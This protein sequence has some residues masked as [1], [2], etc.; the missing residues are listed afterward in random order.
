MVPP[1]REGGAGRSGSADRGG[2]VQNFL[3][4][5]GLSRFGLSAAGASESFFF[6]FL[7]FLVLA[8]FWLPAPSP[9]SGDP[10]TLGI[11]P[12]VS[13]GPPSLP[14]PPAS[15]SNRILPDSSRSISRH[16]STS[17]LRLRRGVG[18][19][20]GGMAVA[21]PPP[22]DRPSPRAAWSLRYDPRRPFPT[23]GKEGKGV[24]GG[25]S[26]RTTLPRCRERGKATSVSPEPGSPGQA[27]VRT[28]APA[29]AASIGVGEAW[30]AQLGTQTGHALRGPFPAVI[31]L[32]FLRMLTH[33]GA[34]SREKSLCFPKG[35]VSSQCLFP[36]CFSTAC[37]V[38]N[39]PCH[40]SHGR[41]T[42]RAI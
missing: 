27:A 22:R 23:W 26:E 17:P 8:S 28:P 7:F 12:A 24:R 16:H 20:G 21:A 42:Y 30:P 31:Q 35:V 5:A 39:C 14:S 41:G 25:G 29:D 37:A 15:L 19:A 6:F 3:E 38:R 11:S 34:P 18:S 32:P 1:R 4:T 9:F 36:E 40:L 33:V 10:R 2:G 13:P